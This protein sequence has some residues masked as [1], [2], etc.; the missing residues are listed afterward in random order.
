M[1]HNIFSL[2]YQSHSTVQLLTEFAQPRNTNVSE[3]HGLRIREKITS[4]FHVPGYDETWN[5]Q[6]S[7]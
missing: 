3:G 6:N 5:F 2:H 7:Y 4:H 1:A